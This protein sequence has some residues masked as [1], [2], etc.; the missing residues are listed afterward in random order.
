V[1]PGIAEHKAAAIRNPYFLE[2]VRLSKTLLY[3]A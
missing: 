2:S 1:T 3:A